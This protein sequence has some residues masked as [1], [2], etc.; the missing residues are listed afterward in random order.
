MVLQ[1]RPVRLT[2]AL[3]VPAS[4]VMLPPVVAAAVE[5]VLPM[6]QPKLTVSAL[7]LS[8]TLPFRVAD[9]G[10]ML[11]ATA[12]VTTGVPGQVMTRLKLLPSACQTVDWPMFEPEVLQPM[13][14]MACTVSVK[15]AM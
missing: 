12:V 1:V 8:T 11:L 10:V 15:A 3:V 13:I 5:L 6:P 9:V 2:L 4:A 7:P 14:C